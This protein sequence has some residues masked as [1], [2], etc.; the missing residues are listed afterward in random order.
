MDQVFHP[1]MLPDLPISMIPLQGHDRLNH[2]QHIVRSDVAQRVRNAGESLF[3]VVGPAHA[4]A[5][6]HIATPQRS[7]RIGE[8]NQAD[9]LGEQIDG[10]VP[11]HR[12][13]HLEFP[14]QV[15]IAIERLRSTAGKHSTFALA[16]AG[17]AHSLGWFEAVAEISVH[18]HVEE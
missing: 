14:R 8:H 17:T 6:I 5:D 1:G 3:L 10:I 4:A 2:I 9:V 16:L 18:P 15:G 12:D 13:T 7:R 11:G